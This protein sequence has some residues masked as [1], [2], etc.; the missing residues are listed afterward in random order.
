LHR[1]EKELKQKQKTEVEDEE[2]VFSSNTSSVDEFEHSDSPRL[3]SGFYSNAGEDESI[4]SPELAI[5]TSTNDESRS[6]TESPLTV[7]VDILTVTTPETQRSEGFVTRAAV[8][9]VQ[10]LDEPESP[11]PVFTFQKETPIEREIRLARERDNEYM[12]RRLSSS[13]SNLNGSGSD[14][15]SLPSTPVTVATKPKPT[16][17]AFSTSAAVIEEKAEEDVTVNVTPVVVKGKPFNSR[18]IQYQM[19]TER[20]KREIQEAKEREEELKSRELNNIP[21]TPVTTKTYVPDYVSVEPVKA[22]ATRFQGV[23]KRKS[24]TFSATVSVDESEKSAAEKSSPQERKNSIKEATPVVE[25]RRFSG[26]A[27]GVTADIPSSP[28]VATVEVSE[29]KPEVSFNPIARPKFNSIER[30]LLKSSVKLRIGKNFQIPTAA[31]SLNQRLQ[32]L[33]LKKLQKH[34]KRNKSR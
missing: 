32:L 15:H 1:R 25:V 19:A 13:T 3:E 20:L 12:L 22:V 21:K 14:F 7:E 5:E 33:L 9:P 16:P 18:D 17:R 29:T 11:P 4:P 27:N 2:D 26:L 6:Q 31:P 10:P 8:S 28:T 23:E 24:Y 34:T 30:Y